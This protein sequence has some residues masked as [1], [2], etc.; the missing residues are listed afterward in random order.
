MRKLE[1]ILYAD[2]AYNIR[3]EAR[4][5]KTGRRSSP[6]HIESTTEWNKT[7]KKRRSVN[8]KKYAESNSNAI[9]MYAILIA[10]QKDLK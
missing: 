9:N 7:H 10:L 8:N 5:K 4:E 2:L 3:A 1:S 6:K